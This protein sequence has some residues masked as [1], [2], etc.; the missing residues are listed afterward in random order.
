[1]AA[2]DGHYDYNKKEGWVTERRVGAKVRNLRIAWLRPYRIGLDIATR[3]DSESGVGSVRDEE[4]QCICSI[5][6]AA[7]E[8]IL[9][10]W[11]GRGA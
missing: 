5:R 4:D 2:R 9:D 10:K 6:R 11:N 3:R 1:M 8:S 7:I